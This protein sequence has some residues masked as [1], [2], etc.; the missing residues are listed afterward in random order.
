MNF[1]QA[2]L[3]QCP[4]RGGHDRRTGW[5]QQFKLVFITNADGRR[6]RQFGSVCPARR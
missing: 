1:S 6:R 3:G 4:V 5:W 2:C